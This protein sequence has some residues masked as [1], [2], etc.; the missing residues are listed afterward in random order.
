[1]EIPRGIKVDTITTGGIMRAVKRN[2][3]GSEQF[4]FLRPYVS[5]MDAGGLVPDPH[6]AVATEI[7]VLQNLFSRAIPHDILFATFIGIN[8]CGK[9]T[10]AELLKARIHDPNENHRPTTAVQILDGGKRK[11]QQV[12]DTE[13]MI[14][15]LREIG[16][17]GTR[18]PIH[19]ITVYF[20]LSI[21]AAQERSFERLREDVR[22]MLAADGKP[23]LRL[24]RDEVLGLYPEATQRDLA[25]VDDHPDKV[26][27]RIVL[28]E[29]NSQDVLERE[30]EANR[31]YK[32]DAS[33]T[34]NQVHQ[35]VLT[36]VRPFLY[37]NGVR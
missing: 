6:I 1:M 17:E 4:S 9:G 36:V 8:G 33:G 2:A 31:L 32:V 14:E 21:Q 5:L 10:Q 25:R 22:K 3:F 23:D 18:V 20:Q 26:R 34:K 7:K 28:Y 12:I 11:L 19:D 35:R 29:K 13:A 27:D 37:T 16:L 30:R 15:R 24:T